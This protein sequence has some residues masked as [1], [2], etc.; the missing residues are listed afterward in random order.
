M[1]NDGVGSGT[2]AVD[3]C[4][5]EGKLPTGREEKSERGRVGGWQSDSVCRLHGGPGVGLAGGG[6]VA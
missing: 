6:L 1:N 2:A 4:A 3:C 5:W